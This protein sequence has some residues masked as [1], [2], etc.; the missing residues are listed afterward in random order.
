[1]LGLVPDVEDAG[2]V[3]KGHGVLSA[4][5]DVVGVTVAVGLI[6]SGGDEEKDGH[7]ARGARGDSLYLPVSS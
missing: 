6:A 2:D 4:R 5:H 7:E 3:I 1:M